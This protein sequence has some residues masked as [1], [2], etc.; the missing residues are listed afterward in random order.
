M[1]LVLVA[2]SI[3]GAA[4]HGAMTH[5]R[6]RNARSSPGTA[7]SY[8]SDLSCEGD[9]CYKVPKANTTRGTLI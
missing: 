2:A 8:G 9:S 1:K 5:P 7:P 4:A 6:P 3:C